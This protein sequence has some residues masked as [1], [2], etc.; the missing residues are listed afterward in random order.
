M[1]AAIVFYIG[2]YALGAL[3]TIFIMFAESPES[4]KEFLQ[5]MLWVMFWP[6]TWILAILWIIKDNIISFYKWWTN[7]ND[8]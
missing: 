8:E 2:G 4:K 6:I 5:N 3:C 1:T 7:L